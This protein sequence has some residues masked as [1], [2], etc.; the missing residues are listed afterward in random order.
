MVKYFSPLQENYEESVPQKLFELGQWT[1]QA[2]GLSIRDGNIE[3]EPLPW[4]PELQLLEL[5]TTWKVIPSKQYV[6]SETS[7]A[8]ITVLLN[9][10]WRIYRKR[11]VC[12]CVA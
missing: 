6:N 8:S 7:V 9:V 2:W 3:L 10:S 1:F 11:V 5:A 12:S 4:G